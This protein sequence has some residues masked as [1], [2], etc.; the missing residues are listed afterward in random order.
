MDLAF[1]VEKLHSLTVI[2]SVLA[3]LVLGS[4]LYIYLTTSPP[5]PDIDRVPGLS[6][7]TAWDFLYRRYDFIAENLAKTTRNAFQFKML[8][9]IALFFF[10]V[11]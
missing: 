11:A 1:V 6:I 8:Q 5:E 2:S 7:L 3:T 4:A 10:F 9:V